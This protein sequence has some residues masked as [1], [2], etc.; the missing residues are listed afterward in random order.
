MAA[1]QSDKTFLTQEW[2]D[3]LQLEF[4]RLKEEDLPATLDRLKEA[5]SQWDIS[6]NAEYDTAMSEKE[7]IEWR[8]WEIELT[9]NNV[10]IIKQGQS[11]WEVTYGSEV[12]IVDDKD[13][14][15]TFTIVWTW[16]VNILEWTM[17]LDSPIW[18]A[19]NGKRKG[20]VVSI[21]APQRKYD[22]K[23]LKVK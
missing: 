15:Q 14:K 12:T 3:K 22:I 1:K 8:M 17:S 2:Y 11:T 5:I 7:L 13:R 4:K 6:E 16:E 20:D 19:I 18:S 23:I 21:K 10:E 9:L